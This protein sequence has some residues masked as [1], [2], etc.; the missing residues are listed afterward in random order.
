MPAEICTCPRQRKSPQAKAATKPQTKIFRR[1][2][3]EIPASLTGKQPGR[4]TENRN[5]KSRPAIRLLTPAIGPP[6]LA[7]VQRDSPGSINALSRF[8]FAAQ[9]A[10]NPNSVTKVQ[11]PNHH[12]T[13][14]TP[15]SGSAPP[16]VCRRG[17]ASL[18]SGHRLRLLQG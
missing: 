7:V 17:I 1:F 3:Q 12:Q 14:E 13:Y 8:I 4:T 11:K 9:L 16:G 10:G 18:C 5:G 15:P 2:I 6:I